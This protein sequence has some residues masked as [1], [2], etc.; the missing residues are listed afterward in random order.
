MTCTKVQ[1]KNHPA[2]RFTTPFPTV[3]SGH[4]RQA[5]GSRDTVAESILLINTMQIEQ[6]KL[7][8]FK[9]S[10]K[11]SRSCKRRG[12]SSWWKST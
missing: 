4:T 1:A 8:D 11:N 12:P 9:E 3:T 7:E 5:Q 6:D 2:V 10:V